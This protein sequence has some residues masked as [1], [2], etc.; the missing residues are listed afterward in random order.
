M[1][2]DADFV[3]VNHF[4]RGLFSHDKIR[5]LK[6]RH[7]NP[8]QSWIEDRIAKGL[9]E[10]LMLRRAGVTI[11][12]AQKSDTF[13]KDS[14]A[15]VALGQG[16]PVIVYVPKLAFGE[17]AAAIDTE[18]LFQKSRAELIGM[19]DSN[20]RQDIDEGVDEQALVSRI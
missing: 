15:S 7:F 17:S 16:K 6:L 14:E 13:G 11:Y 10:A 18:K 1:R 20:D 2:S 8:T 9:V 19:L 3:S 4:V 5:P 12:M